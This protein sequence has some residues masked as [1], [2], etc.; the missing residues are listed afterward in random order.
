MTQVSI[1]DATACKLGEGPLWHPTLGQLFWFDI[2]GQRMMTRSGD[3]LKVWQFDEPV[4]A[5]GWVDD[6]A[7]M[8]ASASALMHF[9]LASGTRAVISPL[10]ADNPAT[11]SN[12]GR[13]DPHGGFWIGTMGRN[14]EPGLGAYYR[15]YRGEL[16]QLYAPWSIPN[17]T[18]F[19]PDGGL[20]YL[21]DTPTNTIWRVRLD[22]DGWP[23]GDREVFLALERGRFHPD[24]AVVDA[25][26]NLWCAHYGCSVVTC[27]DPQGKLLHYVDMPARN[28]TCPAFGGADL[29]TMYVTSAA[30][31]LDGVR[32]P[33]GATLMFHPGAR[34]L[35]EPKVIL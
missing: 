24:G 14:G 8:V 3:G 9:D 35:P 12:D 23:V 16:R 18:C 17:A 2:Q 6:G 31:G 22:K 28:T 15:Y 21:A 7:L 1:F 13:T 25:E 11:R 5:A 29:S 26:G 33:Q 30:G 27:H 32:G 34:G 10:E 19:S 4:S 20:A